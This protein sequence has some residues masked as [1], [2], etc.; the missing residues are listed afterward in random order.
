M[1]PPF[2][3]TQLAANPAVLHC[4]RML[5]GNQVEVTGGRLLRD[6]MHERLRESL[7]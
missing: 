1:V 5:L 3:N 2:T 6:V 7:L 4:M